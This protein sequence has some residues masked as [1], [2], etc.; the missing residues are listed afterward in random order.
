[1][2]ERIHLTAEYLWLLKVDRFAREH[3]IDRSSAIRIL[4]SMAIDW[5]TPAV[6]PVQ[7]IQQAQ[8]KWP[9][10]GSNQ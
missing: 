2:S 7:I 5:L 1:M 6:P 3:S 10:L 4:T 8:P 9:G